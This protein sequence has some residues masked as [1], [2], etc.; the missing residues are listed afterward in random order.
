VADIYDKVKRASI[1]SNISGQDTKPEMLVRKFL[2]ANGFR[3]RKNVKSLPGKPDIV[4][5][6]YKTVVFVHGCF[7]HGHDCKSAKLPET[8]NEF[9]TDKILKNKQRDQHS[10]DELSTLNWRVITVW[11]CDLKNKSSRSDR[12]EKLVLEIKVF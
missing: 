6:K 3:Y 9:W 12:L 4:L 8:R 7:W 10:I 11:Q 5:P 1:M 2:F